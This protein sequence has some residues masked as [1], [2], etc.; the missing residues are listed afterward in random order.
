MPSCTTWGSPLGRRRPRFL[1]DSACQRY[2]LSCYRF[3]CVAPDFT[4]DIFGPINACCSDTVHMYHTNTSAVPL[5][6]NQ[7]SRRISLSCLM[8]LMFRRAPPRTEVGHMYTHCGLVQYHRIFVC[9]Q[10]CQ[11]M[12]TALKGYVALYQAPYRTTGISVDLIAALAAE[13]LPL[14]VF[15]VCI[16]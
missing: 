9:V 10:S 11:A 15:Y 1:W 6:T 5:T 4:E 2:G 12:P 7:W 3:I 8:S 13:A 16:L 14:P